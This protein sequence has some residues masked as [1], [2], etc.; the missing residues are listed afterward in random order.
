MGGDARRAA[1]SRLLTGNVD[2]AARGLLGCVVSANGVS[3]G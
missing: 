1:L 2:V 3:C